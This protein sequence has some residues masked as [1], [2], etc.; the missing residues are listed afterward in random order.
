MMKRTVLTALLLGSAGLWSTS[1]QALGFVTCSVSANGV[2]F[3][4][5]DPH[6]GN[7]LD[8]S[9]SVTFECTLII[10]LLNLRTV[11][12]EVQLDAGSSGSFTPRTLA[13]GNDTLA[14]SLYADAARTTIWGDGTGG[15]VT[16]SGSFLFPA[17]IGIGT[18]R[19]ETFTT[20]GRIF[21]SQFVPAG[22]YND[23]IT[24]TVLY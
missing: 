9:G 13:S 11:S 12:F 19:E 20:Y 4:V 18:T 5:Y 10:G 14:Y 3:G 16:N 6:S 24:V 22:S 2:A 7:D 8:S 17:L 23:T 1:A 21:G 15:T